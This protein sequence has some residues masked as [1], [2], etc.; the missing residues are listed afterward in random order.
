MYAFTYIYVY[1]CIIDQEMHVHLY[2]LP[3]PVNSIPANNLS[4]YIASN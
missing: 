2:Y 1:I 4:K 3:T